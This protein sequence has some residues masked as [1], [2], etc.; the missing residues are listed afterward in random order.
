MGR[1]LW[2]PLRITW[3]V[4]SRRRNLDGFR[5]VMAV[6]AQLIGWWLSL[7]KGGV[8]VS[9]NMTRSLALRL[10]GLV[11]AELSGSSPKR[12]GDFGLFFQ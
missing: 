10:V 4:P 8:I 5:I 7:L 6:D 11:G 3:Y 2:A 1:V 12:V 9:G